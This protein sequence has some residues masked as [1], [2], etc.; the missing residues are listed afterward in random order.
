[1]FSLR[2]LLPLA[3][4]LAFALSASLS[5]QAADSPRERTRLDA[6]WRFAFGHPSDTTQDFGHATG[7]F[8][9]LAKTGFGDGPAAAQFDDRAW[10]V[11]DLPH[12][13]AVEAPFSPQASHSH[14]YKAAGKGFPERSVGWYRKTFTVPESDL[15]RRI[16]VEFDGA[17]RAARVWVNGF[18]LGEHPSGYTGVQYNLTDYLNY[19]GENTISVR[20]DASM[21][22][23]WFYEG[24]GIYRHVYLLKTDPVHVKPWGT[25]VTTDV[26]NDN[27][28]ATVHIATELVHSGREPT[29]VTVEQTLLGPDGQTVASTTLAPVTLA[30]GDEP[31]LKADVDVVS[32]ALWSNVTPQLHTAV[33]TV[34]AADGSVLDR[35]ETTFGIRSIRWDPDQGFFING[36]HLKL[37]GINL[38]QDHAGIGAAL[39]DAMHEFRLRKLMAFGVNAIRVAH[40]LPPPELLDACDRLGLMVIDENR[41]QGINR[42]QL[43]ELRDMIRRDRNHPSVVIWSVGNEEWAIEGN[44]LGA[45]ITQ[46]MQDFAQRLDPSRRNTVAISGGWG[47]SSTTADVVGY[48]YINQSNPDQQHADFPHQPG[49]GTEETSTQST[50]GIFYTDAAK[51]HL[52]PLS[53]GDSG[54]NNEVGWKFYAARPFLAGLFYWTGLDYRGEPTPFA[55]P[56][57]LSQ[58]GLLDICGFPKDSTYYFKSWW[59]DEPTLHIAQHWNWPE[60]LGEETQV[61]VYSNHEAVELFLNGTSLGRQDM[62]VNSKL[63]WMVPYTPGKLEARGYRGGELVQTTIVE[64]TG[65]AAHLTV[66]AEEPTVGADGPRLVIYTLSATDAADRTVPRADNLV[67]LEVSGGTIIGVGNGNPGSHEPDRFIPTSEFKLINGWVGRIAPADITTPADPTTLKPMLELGAYRATLPTAD[68]IYDLTGTFELSEIPADATFD[69]YLPSVGDAVTIWLNGHVL[70]TDLDTTTT[71]PS[72]TLDR[73]LLQVGANRIQMFVTPTAGPNR[74][75]ERHDLGLVRMLTAAPPAQRALFNG[76]AQVIVEADS[77]DTPV[78]LQATSEGLTSASATSR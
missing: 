54:G 5:L 35:Y 76:L 73:E 1:M 55:Y 78:T 23:G 48:N 40:R 60:R 42:A 68:E 7:Y 37:K 2:R 18:Y 26:S 22:E 25:A 34:K 8:S 69:L 45:R 4:L 51:A 62:P 20:V 28:A 24:A 29:T 9:Y 47:G 75:P 61:T 66:S 58:Y 70:A 17:F 21:E 27:T 74:I 46:T 67:S 30:P 72:F 44:I 49:V 33:T 57:A 38:H 15:G 56:A 41:L 12:D 43:D 77:A 64:T 50:R 14:G 13:W 32:P 16:S 39:P 19:G 31:T 6:D 10:R 65:P 3:G 52:A 71:G 53:R 36:Q 63:H 59:T 11:L